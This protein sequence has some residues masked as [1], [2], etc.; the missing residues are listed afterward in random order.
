MNGKSNTRSFS[1][2]KNAIVFLTLASYVGEIYILLR[3]VEGM[4]IVGGLRA[5]LLILGKGMHSKKCVQICFP[6]S[7]VFTNLFS[8]LHLEYVSVISRADLNERWAVY[9]RPGGWNG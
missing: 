5:I 3:G 7:V 9:A 2:R 1:F 8:T 4:E 6:Y